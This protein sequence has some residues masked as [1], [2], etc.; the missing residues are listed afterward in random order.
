M[1]ANATLREFVINAEFR[2]QKVL[3]V[4]GAAYDYGDGARHH[5]AIF[6]AV[7]D[8]V[9]GITYTGGMGSISGLKFEPLPPP[10][11]RG[12]PQKIK[13]DMALALARTWSWLSLRE[14]G[15]F[16]PSAARA[17]ACSAVVDMWQESCWQGAADESA[18]RKN[19]KKAVEELSGLTMLICLDQAPLQGFILAGQKKDFSSE[20]HKGVIFEGACWIWLH[21]EQHAQYCEATFSGDPLLENQ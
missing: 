9:N 13:R 12:R 10:K 14:Q 11:S 21:G 1:V 17:K 3:T 19:I 4:A 16:S 6:S 7:H 15:K 20:P 2:G 5:N 18:L 8:L